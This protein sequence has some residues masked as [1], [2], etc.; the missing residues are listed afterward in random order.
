L[1]YPHFKLATHYFDSF[2][3]KPAITKFDWTFTPNL[4]SSPYFS[5]D[6]G[7]ALQYFLKHLQLAQD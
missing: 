6:V 5:T 4:K 2:R 3:G 7:S 1:L